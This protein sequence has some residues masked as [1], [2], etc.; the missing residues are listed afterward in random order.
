[1]SAIFHSSNYSQSCLCFLEPIS[2]SLAGLCVHVHC[3][4]V[5]WCFFDR[6]FAIVH[7]PF[8]LM[9]PCPVSSPCPFV[10]L[11]AALHS[12]STRPFSTLPGSIAFIIEEYLLQNEEPDI[13]KKKT[14]LGDIQ[15]VTMQNAARTDNLMGNKI[16]HPTHAYKHS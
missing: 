15:E 3:T 9:M 6:A 7:F 1:M 8:G 2:V 11:S 13:R 16:Q 12:S 10:L 5:L 4:Y 14:Y